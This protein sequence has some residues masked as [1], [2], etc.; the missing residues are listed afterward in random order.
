MKKLTVMIVTAL[1]FS[2]PAF[3]FDA[4]TPKA[5]LPVTPSAEAQVLLNRLD[6][7]NAMDK[8]PL[9]KLKKENC[10]KK[11][12]PLKKSLL[13]PVAASIYL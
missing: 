7:I 6:E 10:A 2:V 4:T 5:S 8:A 9:S 12:V 1:L 11:F 3:S 13:S